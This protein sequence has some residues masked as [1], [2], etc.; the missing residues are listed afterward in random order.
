MFIGH[1]G[2]GLAAKPAA[3]KVS[4]GTLFLAA[5]FVDLLWPTLLLLGFERVEINAPPDPLPLTFTHYPISHSLVM[6]VVWAVLFGAGYFA[7][8]KDGRGSLVLGLAVLSHWWLD[9]LVHVP[10]LPL[11]PG[12]G[13]RVGLGLWLF[14]LGAQA[15][16]L[17]LF[18]LGVVL[19]VRATYPRDRMGRWLAVCLVVFLL[20]IQLSNALG[21]PPPSVG[22]IAWVGQ[23][24]WLLVAWGYWLDK[25]REVKAGPVA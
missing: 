21:P 11:Y 6:G 7:V 16:E 17:L 3:P 4:L 14:P 9:W 24:Q 23:S 5:Q 15:A 18:A 22:A 12:G 19:Y 20:L 2:V 10:D 25:H 13:P 1:F 8:R